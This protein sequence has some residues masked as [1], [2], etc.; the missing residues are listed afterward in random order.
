MRITVCGAGGFIGGHLVKR[1]KGQGH[2]VRAVDVKLPEWDASPADEFL[3][4]DLRDED[5]AGKAVSGADQVFQLAADMGGIGYITSKLA[6][7]AANNVRIN[8]NVL[9]AAHAEGVS[10]YLYTSSACVYPAGRQTHSAVVGLR[11]VDAWPADPEKG[12]GVEKLFSEEMALYYAHDFGMNVHVVRLHNVYGPV[13]AWT[14]GREKAP[15]ALCRKVA[16]AP[17]GG[18]VSL[19]G[20]GLQTRSFCYVDDCV[21]GLIRIMASEESGPIN[22]GTE[23]LVSIGTLAEMTAAIAKKSIHFAWDTSKPQG[24]RGRN[25]DN[26]KMRAALGWE[27]KTPLASGLARTYPWIAEQV[28][29]AAT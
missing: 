25:S 11:E 16:E 22:L 27:P 13:G 18:T 19:W 28:S 2:W 4:A 29:M 17:D 5:N 1:L 9:Q 23:E 14:G 12:Y 6:E 3:L 7:I 15:A 10:R 8:L 24:V 20:D 26:T 21:E